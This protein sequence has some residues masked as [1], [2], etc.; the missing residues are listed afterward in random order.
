MCGGDVWRIKTQEKA[1]R[2]WLLEENG[3]GGVVLKSWDFGTLTQ[4][5]SEREKRGRAQAKFLHE[6]FS[7]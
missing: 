2:M 7:P 3:V 4:K 6:W 5:K 1:E